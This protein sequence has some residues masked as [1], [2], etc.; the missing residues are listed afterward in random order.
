MDAEHRAQ[1]NGLQCA[2]DVEAAVL[3][4]RYSMCVSLSFSASSSS[5]W[6]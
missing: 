5:A 2:E 1:R 3:N 4:G 6:A